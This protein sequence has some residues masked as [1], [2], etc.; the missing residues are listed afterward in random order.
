MRAV[1]SGLGERGLAVGRLI[2]RAL[3]GRRL[4]GR[5]LVVLLGTLLFGAAIVAAA[6][7]AQE[8]PFPHPGH[9]GLFPVCAG[10]H[11]GVAT[12]DS[13]TA[14]PSP[15]LCARCHDGVQEEEVEWRAPVRPP[16]NVTFDHSEHALSL[17][18]A[19]DPVQSCESCHSDPSDGRMGVDATEELGTCWSC[20]AHETPGH[21][22]LGSRCESCH[23][24]LAESRF[25][26]NRI[27]ALPHP[28]THD[29]PRFL[30]EE[31]G[32]DVPGYADRCATCHT[33]E[34][35]LTC[36]VDG[37]LI[38]IAALPRAPSGMELPETTAE[39]PVPAS[40]EDEGWLDAHRLQVPVRECSTCHTQDDCRSCHVG[41]VPTFVEALPRASES[42]AP[43]ARLVARAP[44]SHESSFFLNA[45]SVL[46]SADGQSCATCHV[47]S[48]C[49]DCHDGPP[50]GGYHPASFVA[51]HAADAFARTD[52]CATCH[53]TEV[54][55]R[56]CHLES[57]F[58]SRGRLGSGYH[59]A[60][61]VWL[62]RHGQAARQSLETCASCHA[63]GDCVQC[64][65]VLGSFSLSPHSRDFD[66]AA[67]WAQSPRTCLACHVS[68]PIGEVP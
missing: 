1:E 61:P 63:Q 52:E 10:C 47:E 23:V 15:D 17:A 32:R 20:H 18:E 25:G 48:Y 60:E 29:D 41:I 38:E 43:G 53:S 7:A 27:A 37:T 59:D 16:S 31:H 67:A 62:L 68:N 6:R 9:A 50:D 34:R 33:A 56:A 55:C 4:A 2:G 45:H 22:D 12:G 44:E 13:T 11:A 36:H 51:R 66:A 65:G 58:G 35:C 30:A 39:Y 14:Y 54:F 57:G 26:R 42:L 8:D 28:A 40:H 46:A 21:F 3:P 19:G 24:P 64:H 49:V 5:A